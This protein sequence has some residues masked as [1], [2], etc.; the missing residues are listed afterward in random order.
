MPKN[1]P[2]KGLLKRIR[3]TK[4]GKIKMSRAYGRHLRSH[5][6]ASLLRRYRVPKYASAS[7]AGRIRSMLFTKVK[8]QNQSRAE[9]TPAAE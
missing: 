7:D 1:K 2:N 6:S 3:V 5:K 4:S 9:E 8:S